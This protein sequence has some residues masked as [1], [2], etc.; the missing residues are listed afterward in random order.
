MLWLAFVS[1]CTPQ[2]DRG[3]SAR[4]ALRLMSCC[5]VLEIRGRLPAPPSQRDTPLC[6]PGVEACAPCDG[7][8][9][10]ALFGW[11]LPERP[12]RLKAAR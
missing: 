8:R 12:G 2:F 3:L 7:G 11:P 10:G 9:S 6:A 4:P 1:L 5:S